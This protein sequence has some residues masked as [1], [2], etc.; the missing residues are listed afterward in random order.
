MPT[1][2]QEYWDAWNLDRVREGLVR[3]RLPLNDEVI[4]EVGRL[5]L[6]NGSKLL[7]VGCGAGWATE[8]LHRDFDYLGLDLSEKAI[9]AATERLPGARLEAADFIEWSEPAS[10]Y[11]AIL[12]VDSIAYFRDQD[13]VVAK[14]HRALKPGGVLVLSTV[15]LFIYSR[16]KWVK[17]PGKHHTR[18]W[19]RRHELHDLLV[20]HGFVVTRSRTILP[21]GDSGWLRLLNSRILKKAMPGPVRR[22]YDRILESVGLGQFRLV[23]ARRA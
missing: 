11:D 8:R 19:L 3:E 10:H 5:Q 4:A 17:P 21:S 2:E 14:M 6:P 7:D 23:T 22:L 13:V 18:K 12:S 9:A 15:N 20:R 16:M 1:P